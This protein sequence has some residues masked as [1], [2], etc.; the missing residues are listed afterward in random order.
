MVSRTTA[1]RRD[2]DDNAETD[3]PETV[4]PRIAMTAMSA[5]RVDGTE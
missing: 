2:L 1:A 5:G 4:G 3:G